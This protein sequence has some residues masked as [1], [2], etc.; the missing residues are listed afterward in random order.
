MECNDC[1]EELLLPLAYQ[2]SN[3]FQEWRSAGSLKEVQL[4]DRK[5]WNPEQDISIFFIF[6]SLPKRL[7]DP[8]ANFSDFV[9]LSR[10]QTDFPRCLSWIFQSWS[11][12]GLAGQ[13]TLK[14]PG[15]EQIILSLAMGISGCYIPQYIYLQQW[16][17]FPKKTSSWQ[18]DSRKG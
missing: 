14:N 15:V 16:N 3:I 10:Y 6:N 18:P 7:P 1:F 11:R 2:Y 12:V 8:F 13:T 9:A 5:V 17:K 4:P